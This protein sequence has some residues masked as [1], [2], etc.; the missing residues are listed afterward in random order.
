MANYVGLVSTPFRQRSP[1]FSGM[2]EALRA[3]ASV[4]DGRHGRCRRRSAD[5]PVMTRTL[6]NGEICGR[7]FGARELLRSRVYRSLEEASVNSIKTSIWAGVA[8]LLTILPACVS[9]DASSPSK[10]VETDVAADGKLDATSITDHGALRLVRVP[11]LRGDVGA[12]GSDWAELTTTARSHAWEFELSGSANLR[13]KVLLRPNG[14]LN[15]DTVMYLY[16]QRPDG[17]WGHYIRRNDD[18]GDVSS[19]PYLSALEEPHVSN[20]TYR[21]VVKGYSRSEV[22]EFELH[23]Q[24]RGAGCINPDADESTCLEGK[25]IAELEERERF[26]V[27]QATTIRANSRIAGTALR[28]ILLA[29]NNHAELLGDDSGFEELDDA[30]DYVDQNEIGTWNV[31]DTET[32]RSFNVVEFAMGDTIVG[33]LFENG[34]MDVVAT[35]ADSEIVAARGEDLCH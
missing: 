23:V 16:R 1:K 25:D 22:G 20:G 24:C 12:D 32:E 9:T 13:L 30:L 6:K 7:S 14:N 35:I 31:F 21:V 2:R 3:S 18:I 11:A 15:L 8:L 27:G 10:G 4:G 28:Q 19:T 17:R 34:T 5:Q 26:E 33:S 29:V